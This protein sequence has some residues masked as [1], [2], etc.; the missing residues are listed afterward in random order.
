MAAW[1]EL[2]RRAADFFTVEVLTL[3]GLVRYHVLFIIKLKTRKVEIAGITSV[4]CE[5][6][7]K[8]IAKNLTDASD[9]F[10]LDVRY[11]ILDRDSLYTDSF[12][13]LLSSSGV[14]PLR[15]PAKSPNLN[16]Y[17]ERFVLTIKSECLGRMVPLGERHLRS[18]IQQYVEHYHEERPHQGIGNEMIRPPHQAPP[19]T[20]RVRRSERLGG[21]LS[22]YYREAA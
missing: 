17:A 2:R 18:A 21:M 11:L 7:M 1:P 20:G 10:L 8:Q 13:H 4:P 12:R 19:R 6:W 9:G 5:A 16:A 14:E 22:Y 15:L 3:A